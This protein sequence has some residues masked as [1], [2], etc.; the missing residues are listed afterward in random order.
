MHIVVL[1]RPDQLVSAYGR[2]TG[3]IL[4]SEGFAGYEMR[5]WRPGDPLSL[6]DAAA[7]ILTPCILQYPEV[8]ALRDYVEQGGNL[9]AFQPMAHMHKA[10][11][12]NPLNKVLLDG[13]VKPVGTYRVGR[14]IGGESIQFHGSASK[15][16][17]GP[18]Y[19]PVAWLHTETDEP[20]P[21][22]AVA[23]AKIGQGTF[24]FFAYDLPATVAAIRQG[25][26]RL[27]YQST[28]GFASDHLQRPNDL[29]SGHLDT[30]KGHIPQ[31]DVHCNLLTHV[32][33]KVTAEPQPRLWYF[34]RPEMTSVVVMT[35]D[36]DWSTLE[37]YNALLAAVEEVGGHIHVFMV[38]DSRQPPERVRAWIKRGHSFSPHTNPR[39]QEMDPYW[40]MTESIRVH[41]AEAEAN[42]GMPS[43]VYRSHCVHW[44][45]YVESARILADA[46]Y[47]MDSSIISLLDNWGLYTNGSGRPM[48]FVDE[49]GDI[50]DLFEQSVNFYDDGSVMKV[51]TEEP[52]TEIARATLA[53]REA[54]SK[55]F[56]P[57]GFLSH[58]VSFF[59]YS[60]RFVKGVLKNAHEMGLPV[61]NMDEFLEFTLARD[62]ARIESRSASEDSLSFTVTLGRSGTGVT[63]MAPVPSGKQVSSVRLNGAPAEWTTRKVHG[64]DYVLVGLPAGEVGTAAEIRLRYAAAPESQ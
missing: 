49:N 17:L 56:V 47:Q 63:A 23:T 31:A 40:H 35:S 34:E 53:V 33:N 61:L 54:A 52:E 29:F 30:A 36:D 51:L 9:I 6:E 5:E 57:F 15:V 41:K 59:T 1:Y 58:P 32:I 62:A 14:M 19:E 44:Q 20:S 13:Y 55:Y 24:T 16:V 2:F 38:R 25:D 8:D 50:I 3:E 21:H 22:A 45:G 42:Y 37:H 64:W 7:T 11:G 28:A 46:G 10:F 43:R 26:P 4:R 18:D 27:A 60:S 12:T 48:R 39:I